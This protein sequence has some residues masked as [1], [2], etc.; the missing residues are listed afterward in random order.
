MMRVQAVLPLR[1]GKVTQEHNRLQT[2]VRIP[3]AKLSWIR[4]DMLPQGEG[5]P[6][7][8]VGNHYSLRLGSAAQLHPG[9]GAL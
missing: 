9:D 8:T 6:L 2:G 3:T 1:R 7:E 4:L 5:F